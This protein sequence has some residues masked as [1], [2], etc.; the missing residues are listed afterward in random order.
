[1]YT[2]GL[3]HMSKL[4]ALAHVIPSAWMFLPPLHHEK[5]MSKGMK[6]VFGIST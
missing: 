4:H 3:Y 6:L 2:I 5:N 1:M